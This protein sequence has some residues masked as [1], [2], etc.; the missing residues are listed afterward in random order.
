MSTPPTPNIVIVGGGENPG[1]NVYQAESGIVGGGT[2]LES[3]NVG[4]NGSGYVNSSA[5]GGFAEIGNVDGRGGGA[6]TM[7]LRF[8]LGATANR[9]GRLLVNGAAQDITFA[10]TGAWTT[11]VTMNVSVTLNNGTGNVIRFESNGQD[12]GNVDQIEIL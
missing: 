5:T 10:P 11:W 6:K 4:Y 9:T 8:A 2:V 3:T 1:T 7:R 12:L